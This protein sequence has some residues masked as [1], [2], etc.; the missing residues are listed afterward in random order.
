MSSKCIG[1]DNDR[2]K[3]MRGVGIRA[4]ELAAELFGW[5]EEKCREMFVMGYLHDVGY[6]YSLDQLEHEEIGGAILRRSG[7]KYWAEVYH[8]G[9]PNSSYQS[10]E[11]FIL[12]VA[13]M[14]TSKDGHRITMDDRLDDIRQRY[15]EESE[16]FLKAA[17]LIRELQDRI[18]QL[19]GSKD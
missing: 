15:G 5:N 14:E 1:I 4:S 19:S 11:L 2:L 3:H 16:Q 12:N 18:R 7:Y 6:H 9:V 13:D 8:H 17:I 10:D